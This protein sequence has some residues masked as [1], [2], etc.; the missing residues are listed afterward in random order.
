MGKIEGEGIGEVQETIDIC[1]YACGLSRS[2]N[3]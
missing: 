3:G 1:D 2:L